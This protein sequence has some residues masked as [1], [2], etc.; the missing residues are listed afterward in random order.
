MEELL[1]K[2]DITFETADLHKDGSIIP[3]EVH[4]RLIESG[5]K[6]FVLSIARNITERQKTQD[7]LI[8]TDRLAALGEMALGFSHELNNPLT[9]VIGYSQ[10]LLDD[11]KLT[12]NTRIDAERIHSQAQR[13]AAVIKNFLVFARKQAPVKQPTYI[14]SVI[15]TVLKLR[16][17][18][19]KM[20]NINVVTNLS[21]DLPAVMADVSQLQQVFLNIVINAEY[22]MLKAHNKGTLTVTTER[23]G[24][25][26]KAS[27]AN[28]GP[29]IPKEN[30][31]NIFNPFFTTKKVGQGT[32]L[33]LNICH[34]I[35][36]EH[37]GRIYAES[38]PGKDVTFV[39]E[40]PVAK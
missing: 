31:T 1:A 22:F 24:D 19:D 20:K 13:A 36:S 32:G 16:E 2:G 14:N 3:M 11:K 21:P 29:V 12:K 7:K 4:A 27:F 35:I 8:V 15:N 33:G 34:G 9:I 40:L 17:Y 26:V 30:L 6:K 37:G 23:A 39:V 25:V 10:L 28:D 38:E 18:E 5:G